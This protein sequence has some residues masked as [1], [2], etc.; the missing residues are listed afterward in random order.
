MTSKSNAPQKHPTK[1][2][3]RTALWKKL[4]LLLGS[5][6]FLLL[7]FEVT[8]RVIG[9]RPQTATVL[10]SYFRYDDATGWIGRPDVTCRLT[11]TN[12]NVLISHDADGLRRCGLDWSLD[13]DARRDEEIVW[14]VGDSGTWGLGVED[15]KTYVDALNRADVGNRAY[16]NFGV[17][18]FSTLQEYLLLKEHF[19]MG[20]IPDRVI[21]LFCINDLYDNLAVTRSGSRDQSPPRPYLKVDGGNIEICNQPVPPAVGWNVR[22]W[23]KTNSLAYNHLY[24][25]AK[26][27]SLARCDRS[28]G[29]DMAKPQYDPSADEQARQWS[30]L[31]EAYRMIDRLCREHGVALAVATELDGPVAESL[32]RICDELSVPMLDLSCRWQEHFAASEDARPLCFKTDPHYN[33]LGHQLLAEAIRSELEQLRTASVADSRRPRR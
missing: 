26:R 2:R 23:L 12:F 30:T 13:D 5:L 24:Y 27:A 10:S 8:L 11:T 14:C 9:A 7:A 22:G 19:A 31:R 6:V 28:G 1:K 16:R 33:E 18:G 29:K 20:R 3:K 32:S 15:G 4:L 25:Y 17:C 21:V